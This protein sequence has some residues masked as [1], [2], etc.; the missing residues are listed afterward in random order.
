MSPSGPGH[1]RSE[2]TPSKQLRGSSRSLASGARNESC[3]ALPRELLPTCRLCP[4]ARVLV[5]STR[6]ALLALRQQVCDPSLE[7]ACDAWRT[8]P[9]ASPRPRPAAADL[10][11]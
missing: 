5:V 1:R 4:A 8:T 11:N 10:A 6:L 9:R 2:S 3:S 7:V